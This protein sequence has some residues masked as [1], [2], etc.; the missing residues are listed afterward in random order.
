MTILR[1]LFALLA[2]VSLTACT[3]TTAAQR[4]YNSYTGELNQYVSAKITCINAAS[5]SSPAFN[6]IFEWNGSSYTDKAKKNKS[7]ISRS[8]KKD[9]EK[10]ISEIEK[11][12]ERYLDQVQTS[13]DSYVRSFA[14]IVSEDK[15][16]RSEVYKKYLG[17]K[18][19]V[20]QA[21][22]SFD[23]ISNSLQAKSDNQQQMIVN[24]LNQQDFQEKQAQAAMLQAI[25]AGFND[26]SN[27]QQQYY[28]QRQQNS[29]RSVY[30]Q[31]QWV[32]NIM[33]CTSF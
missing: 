10:V 7:Y 16:L 25:G 1:F 14:S 28:Q 9:F 8:N 20:G 15:N 18:I 27:Q 5:V 17:G 12:R 13:S 4:T 29:P 19:T 24:Q 31:C 3:T 2:S 6:K 21:S 22:T 33:S 26:Y 11:C 32:G 23:N 30:T